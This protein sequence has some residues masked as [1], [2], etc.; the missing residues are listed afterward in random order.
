MDLSKLSTEDLLALKSGD[1]SKVSTPGLMMLKGAPTKSIEQQGGEM[2]L[3]GMSRTDKFRAGIGK[4]LSD[5][6][7]GSKQLAGFGDQ[8]EI[9][10]TKRRDAPLTD[11]WAGF[12][13]NLAGNVAAFAP[14]AMI[15][16]ANTLTGAGV[17]GA[18]TG[19]LQPVAEGESRGGNMGLG[20]VGGMGGQLVGQAAGRLLRPVRAQLSPQ[21]AQLAQQAQARGIP[22]DAADLT[23]SK[24]L[25]VMRDVMS[26]LPLTADRQAAAQ[27]AK[28]GAFNRA[29]TNTFGASEESVT[30]QVLQGARNRIGQEFT[31]LSARNTLQA[32]NGLVQEL[33]N[34]EAQAHRSMTPDVARVVT[35][36]IDDVLSRVEPGD[37]INGQAYRALDSELGRVTRTTSNGDI[38]HGVGLVREALRDAMDQSISAADRTA[39]QQARRQYANLMTVAPLAARSETG[40]VSGRTLLAAALRQRK[41][42]AFNG[43]GD[44]GELGRIGRAFVAEQTPNSGTAQR[45]F[46]Q[47]MLTENPLTA[48]WQQGVGGI[49]YPMQTM[50]NSPAGQR[51]LSQG[52]V[53]ITP[54]QQELINALMRTSGA[55]ALPSVQSAQ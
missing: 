24:P 29:V 13:G 30:P 7:A 26:N 44:L 51:Y 16:G 12:A 39:W 28:Q 22:L 55:A 23:G 54:R 10:E 35:N 25:K 9:N 38:R 14:T 32:S 11:T 40:D 37:V 15:P 4:A 27:A 17:I 2:A 18:A 1:L 21:A 53:N 8:N 5:I 47:R 50:L 33:A 46:Y 41:S 49:S 42:A 45:S 36:H 3:E 48:A 34:I 31:D 6:V 52:A 43:G 19:A 20:A